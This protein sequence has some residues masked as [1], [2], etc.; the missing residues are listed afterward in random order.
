MSS[1]TRRGLFVDAH[2]LKVLAITLFPEDCGRAVIGHAAFAGHE[3]VNTFGH[4]S[5]VTL[6]G[7]HELTT[8]HWP[9]ARGRPLIV[10]M[11]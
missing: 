11:S 2:F 7:R 5:S 1:L 10:A 8:L 3:H 9:T 6:D 4:A